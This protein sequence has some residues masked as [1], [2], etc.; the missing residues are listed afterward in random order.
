MAS[1]FT[2]Y[3]STDG[4]PWL[5][6]GGREKPADKM[7]DLHQDKRTPRK[8]MVRSRRK[9]ASSSK[10]QEGKIH[11]SGNSGMDLMESQI[12]T[13]MG[14]I[15]L[16]DD[17]PSDATRLENILRNIY[18][19]IE[20]WAMDM[21]RISRELDFGLLG[22]NAMADCNRVMAKQMPAQNLTA[23]SERLLTEVLPS[24]K[25][26]SVLLRLVCYAYDPNNRPISF[27]RLYNLMV[28]CEFY[29]ATDL[30]QSEITSAMAPTIRLMLDGLVLDSPNLYSSDYQMTLE[31]TRDLKEM[32]Q[33]QYNWDPIEETFSGPFDLTRFC[34]ELSL[35]SQLFL[36]LDIH[37]SLWRYSQ[38]H[39]DVNYFDP[40]YWPL[41][42]YTLEG[43]SEQSIMRKIIQE[44]FTG[45]SCTLE[46]EGRSSGESEASS[47]IFDSATEVSGGAD[48]TDSD[49]SIVNDE[50]QA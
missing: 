20:K 34:E 22:L 12:S 19:R 24:V 45:S 41:I 35:A 23:Y 33:A 30:L 6:V 4:S 25:W 26:K 7:P 5:L 21:I 3:V 28:A 11:T 42:E 17:Q 31:L 29:R 47:H 13:V 40:Y 2:E 50:Q 37:L 38:Y 48:I 36:P 46:E 27:T 9:K 8:S 15:N 39:L 1:T 16:D 44:S 14:A 43:E 49:W 10:I 32:L 18:Q